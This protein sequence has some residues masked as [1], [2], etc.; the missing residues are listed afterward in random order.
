MLLPTGHMFGW[1]D[2]RSAATAVE[3][4]DAG[5]LLLS[6]YRD[7]S[8]QPLP[9]QAALHAAAVR[10]G[11][12]RR[13]AFRLVGAEPVG[14]A[15]PDDAE[16]WEVLISHRAERGREVTYRV[17]VAPTTA[18][19]ALLSCTDDLPKAEARYATISFSEPGGNAS[20]PPLR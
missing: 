14:D 18:S 19:P 3:R 17:T 8:G 20:L 10:L 11:N 2:Q 7:R 15:R 5:Q 4:F 6:H 13:H 9:V 12:S 1:L 16:L